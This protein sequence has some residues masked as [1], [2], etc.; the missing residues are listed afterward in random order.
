MR[1]TRDVDNMAKEMV[2]RFFQVFLVLLGALVP[3]VAAMDG[4]DV[5]ALIILL[6]IGALGTCACLG[7]YARKKQPDTYN[8]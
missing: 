3:G 4:G 8:R 7:W 6:V 1:W 5:A 2:L